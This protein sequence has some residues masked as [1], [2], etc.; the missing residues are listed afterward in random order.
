MNSSALPPL[1]ALLIASSIIAVLTSGSSLTSFAISPASSI[2]PDTLRISFIRALFAASSPNLTIEEEYTSSTS[3]GDSLAK[4][5][6][7]EIASLAPPLIAAFKI[8]YLG[9]MLRARP[10][11]A[12]LSPPPIAPLAAE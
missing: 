4:N 12:A 8:L 9:A 3:L 10:A 7:S 1:P 5:G 6:T 11:V 2:S